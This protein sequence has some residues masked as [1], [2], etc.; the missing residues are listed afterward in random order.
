MEPVEPEKLVKTDQKD[1][2][3]EKLVKKAEKL[4]KA[5]E[6]VAKLENIAKL[7]KVTKQEKVAKQEKLVKLKAKP[8][9]VGKKEFEVDTIKEEEMEDNE[10]VRVSKTEALKAIDLLKQYC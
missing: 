9:P 7:E 4:E 8:T 10:P 1:S 5:Y 6:K 2:K 3:L